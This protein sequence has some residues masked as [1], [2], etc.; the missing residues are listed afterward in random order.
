MPVPL[1]WKYNIALQLLQ[2]SFHCL[3]ARFFLGFLELE[4][5]LDVALVHRI[6]LFPL[7]TVLFGSALAELMSSCRA[8]VVGLRIRFGGVRCVEAGEGCDMLNVGSVV[9]AAT[10]LAV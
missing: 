5:C 10:M 6:A 9:V 1:Y 4:V 2:M 8:F 7:L 3:V